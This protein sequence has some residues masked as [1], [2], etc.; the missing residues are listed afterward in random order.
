MC[1]YVPPDKADYIRNLIL[2]FLHA[3]EITAPQRQSL[4]GML[5]ALHPAIYLAKLYVRSLYSE[6]AC[7]PLDHE[8]IIPFSQYFT[9]DLQYW[10]NILK[11]PLPGRPMRFDSFRTFLVYSDASEIGG[12]S[13]YRD[14][15]SPGAIIPIALQNWSPCVRT[16]SSTHKQI[17]QLSEAALALLNEEKAFVRNSTIHLVTDSK[18]AAADISGMKGAPAIFDKVK[19]MHMAAHAAGARI[20]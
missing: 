13:F 18:S 20:E 19:D 10:A 3:G 5:L 11:P 8:V 9:Q 1:T 2:E 17:L 7:V 12:G 14:L 6:Q 15:I 16:A 4:G